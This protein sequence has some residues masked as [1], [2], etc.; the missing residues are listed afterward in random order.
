M[1]ESDYVQQELFLGLAETPA[2]DSSEENL[3][4]LADP[5]P[6]EH[7]SISEDDQ[8]A[9]ELP[10]E[11][12]PEG[13]ADEP[14]HQPD[15]EL[16]DESSLNTVL[17]MLEAIDSVEELTLLEDLTDAQKRQVWDVTPEAIKIKLKQIRA[18]AT[19]E[20]T[21]PAYLANWDTSEAE[22]TVHNPSSLDSFLKQTDRPSP[23]QP[24]PTVGDWVVLIAKPKLTA[25]ELIAI[26]EVIE[27]H[28][29]YARIK[30]KGIGNRNYPIAWMVIYP[31]PPIE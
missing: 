11:S 24:I 23:D 14:P 20:T 7:P 31:K 16:L 25:A 1:P 28:E 9:N 18:S 4:V 3:P 26:W 6:E 12:L 19:T 29:Y 30:A 22:A 2:E 15:A 27:I 5:E 10:E 17:A 13:D 8:T 21:D